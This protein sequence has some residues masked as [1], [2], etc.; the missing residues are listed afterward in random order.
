MSEYNYI[1]TV[2]TKKR[3]TDTEIYEIMYDFRSRMMGYHTECPK[4]LINS[5]IRIKY[6]NNR[7]KKLQKIQKLLNKSV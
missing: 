2:N 1:I 6:D 3:L 5:D 7:L 4:S